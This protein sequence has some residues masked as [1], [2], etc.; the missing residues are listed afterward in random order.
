[1]KQ[2]I[3]KIVFLIFAVIIFIGGGYVLYVFLNTNDNN[4]TS[5]IIKKTEA[6]HQ[7][8]KNKKKNIDVNKTKTSNKLKPMKAKSI[9]TKKEL[10]KYTSENTQQT[11]VDKIDDTQQKILLLKQKYKKPFYFNLLN[12]SF[13]GT[14]NNVL[15]ITFNTYNLT[16]K[17]YSGLL[18]IKCKTYDKTDKFLDTVNS[19]MFL[20]IQGMSKKHLDNYIVGITISDNVKKVT[21]SFNTNNP[22]KKEKFVEKNK[23]KIVNVPKLNIQTNDKNNKLPPPLKLFN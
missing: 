16:K 12:W 7:T 1:M 19:E 22:I 15:L 17:P 21:C 2:K 20:S 18:N 10:K 11:K 23:T 3:Q 6:H 4:E 9:F 14:N 5:K 8:A 13:G